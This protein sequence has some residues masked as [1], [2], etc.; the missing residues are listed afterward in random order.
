MRLALAGVPCEAECRPV[1]TPVAGLSWEVLLP[2]SWWQVGFILRAR[3]PADV[4]CR[5]CSCRRVWLSVAGDFRVGF[6]RRVQLPVGA[7]FQ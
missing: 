3:Q 6:N 2:V 1:L 7:D 4:D 5:V